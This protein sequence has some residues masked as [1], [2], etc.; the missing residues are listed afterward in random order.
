MNLQ[1]LHQVPSVPESDR[2]PRR[3]SL[4]EADDAVW[5]RHVAVDRGLG[6][7]RDPQLD[8]GEDDGQNDRDE[9][10]RAVRGEKAEQAAHQL[11]VE[12]LSEDLVVEE[13]VAHS[14]TA[15]RSACCSRQIR[16]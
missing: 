16:W 13:L 10:Q 9:E 7:I 2:V 12:C 14:P 11:C 1:G 15:C 5:E 8:E 6:Q 3:W 4:V